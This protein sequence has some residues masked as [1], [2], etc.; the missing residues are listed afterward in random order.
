[1]TISSLTT[2]ISH[3]AN[4]TVSITI[5]KKS[6][7]LNIGET[8][9]ILSGKNDIDEQN[10]KIEFLPNNGFQIK[11]RR[12]GLAC[13]LETD[14]FNYSNKTVF[15]RGVFPKD[16]DVVENLHVF[17]TSEPLNLLLLTKYPKLKKVSVHNSETSDVFPVLPNLEALQI[18]HCDDLIDLYNIEQCTELLALKIQWCS[19]LKV[20]PKIVSPKLKILSVEWCQQITS[21]FP[22]DFPE[23]EYCSFIATNHDDF[24]ALANCHNVKNLIISWFKRDVTL[25][26]LSECKQLTVLHLRSLGRVSELPALAQ[27]SILEELDLSDMF[28]LKNLSLPV[29]PML[30]TLHADGCRDLKTVDISNVSTLEHLSLLRT[31]TLEKLDGLAL[32]PLLENLELSDS[33]DLLSLAD[34]TN[35]PNLRSI[36]LNNCQSLQ[37]LPELHKVPNLES[38]QIYNCTELAEVK[39]KRNE[40]LKILRIGGCRSIKRIPSFD[41]FPSLE[42]LLIAWFHSNTPIK[43][44]ATLKQLRELRLSGH[45]GLRFLNLHGLNQL[46]KID[47]SRCHHLE[48]IEG[49]DCVSLRK[50]IAEECHSLR[51]LS[52]FEKIQS[53]EEVVLSNCQTLEEIDLIYYQPKLLVLD[54]SGCQS[55]KKMPAFHDKTLQSLKVLNLSNRPYPTDLS[56]IVA[57]YAGIEVLNIE[58][59]TQIYEFSPLINLPNLKELHGLSVAD[60]DNVLCQIFLRYGNIGAISSH[61]SSFFQSLPKSDHISEFA[62]NIISA[63]DL[64]DAP[65]KR[66]QELFEL[67]QKKERFSLGDSPVTEGVWTFFFNL[68]EQQRFPNLKLGDL[69]SSKVNFEQEGNCL[70]GFLT[71]LNEDN[72]F[73]KD[74]AALLLEQT[75][76]QSSPVQQRLYEVLRANWT[77]YLPVIDKT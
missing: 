44:V 76:L 21:L 49:S 37:E 24:S 51:R 52:G 60:R 71:I 14:P 65:L 35:H 69:F 70:R 12:E 38:L 22:L 74:D 25:P 31:P 75:Y 16:T 50:L 33:Q 43:N 42:I 73:K 36:S 27:D 9:F 41:N 45:L 1:M 55:L 17:S 46:E 53:L 68:L 77:Q 47:C 56:K 20:L 58:S 29:L 2:Q 4:Q 40:N 66:W 5:Q 3:W 67:L 23:L 6:L 32:N 15:T 8:Q 26:N 62:K 19:S 13:F 39:S 59:V 64:T 63:L 18:Q 10:L 34:L 30:K 61:I 54:I 72:T 48:T 28:Q 57:P 7:I 11:N